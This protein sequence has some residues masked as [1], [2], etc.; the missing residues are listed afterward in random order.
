MHKLILYTTGCPKCVILKKVLDKKQLDYQIEENVGIM[1]SRGICHVP[2]LSVDG[3]MLDFATS[4][5][6]VATLGGN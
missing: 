5:K 6:W 3:E 2:V 4:F 1:Q